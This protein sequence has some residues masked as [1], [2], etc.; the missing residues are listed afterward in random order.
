MQAHD[1]LQSRGNSVSWNNQKSAVLRLYTLFRTSSAQRSEDYDEEFDNIPEETL[2]S[3]TFF[4][5][6]AEYLVN[7]YVSTTGKK[8]G[9]PLMID[10]IINYHGIALNMAA[11]L[12]MTTGTY[13]TKVF[14]RCM[15]KNSSLES[16][17][18]LN[19]LRKNMR[20]VWLQA[21][22]ARGEN[23][24]KARARYILVTSKLFSPRTLRVAVMKVQS[25]SL[26]FFLCT[27]QPAEQPKR[28][29]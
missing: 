19:G 28:R 8:K 3:K 15:E 11:D 22:L 2:C 1:R 9:N 23:L 16:G 18:W 7:E 20:R 17:M 10:P 5:D 6:F 26:R 4:T 12:Y 14:L 25:A 29:R 13:N 24:I 21:A 27:K